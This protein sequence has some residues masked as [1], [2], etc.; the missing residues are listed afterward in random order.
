MSQ[1][2][3]L[4]NTETCSPSVLFKNFNKQ[5]KHNVNK[6]ARVERKCMRLTQDA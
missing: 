6:K 2:Q 4:S 1:Q 3:N 5:E